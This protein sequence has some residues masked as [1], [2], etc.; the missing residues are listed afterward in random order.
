MNLAS[1]P[2]KRAKFLVWIKGVAITVIAA[3]LVVNFFVAAQT[4]HKSTEGDAAYRTTKLWEDVREL[5]DVIAG[6]APGRPGP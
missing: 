6:K 1:Q 2:G 3:L 4:A 5:G